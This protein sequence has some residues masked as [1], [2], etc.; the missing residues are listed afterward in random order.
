M[1]DTLWSS[2]TDAH[3]KLPMALTAEK[4]AEQYGITRE[5]CDRFALAS[6]QRWANGLCLVVVLELLY[7]YQ[8]VMVIGFGNCILRYIGYVQYCT[9]LLFIALIFHELALIFYELAVW[10]N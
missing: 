9:A 1:E 5:D 4:L 6:Q 7:A 8:S 10:L 2:L 3:C